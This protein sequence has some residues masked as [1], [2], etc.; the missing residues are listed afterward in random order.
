MHKDWSHAHMNGANA[1]AAADAEWAKPQ[2]QAIV[3]EEGTRRTDRQKRSQSRLLLDIITMTGVDLYHT[4][5]GTP[6]ADLHVGGRR[7]T[8]PV[9][10][11]KFRGWLLRE[12]YIR[13]RM[14]ASNNAMSEALAVIEA[15]AL[16]DGPE[17]P[18]YLRVAGDDGRIY[19]DLVDRDWR[20]VE[21]GPDGWRIVSQPP[22]RFRRT[23]GMMP[24]PTPERG[25]SIDELRPHLNV[26]EDGFVLVVSWLLAG[27]RPCGPYPILALTGE[28]GTGKSM[29]AE[30]VRSL[31]DPNTAPLRP[32]PRDTRDLY[33][34][35]INGHV[36]VFDNLSSMTNEISDCLC[37]LSTG[38]GFATRALFTDSSEVLF[39]GQRPIALTSIT[40]V[41]TRSDL[42]DRVIICPLLVIP[43]TER[44]TEA[45]LRATFEKAKP[46]IL[47]A[48]FDVIAHGLMQLPH[49]QLDRAPRMADYAVWIRACETAIWAA[50]MHMAA[51]EAN[52]KDAVEVVLDCDPVATA[53]LQHMQGR[54]EITTTATE[55]LATL[56][57]VVSDHVRRGA[58]WPVTARTLSGQLKRLAPALRRVGI[59]VRHDRQS[60][61]RL[62]QIRNVNAS[63]PTSSSFASSASDGPGPY[64]GGLS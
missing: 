55:L 52:R 28:Q 32:L 23:A 37:R 33:I 41:A 3:Q 12:Y 13:E 22:V 59:E 11:P 25:G 2:A 54:S 64:A 30:K 42:A 56:S 16:F 5:D 15:R 46:R 49:T 45:A 10:S 47:G 39:N 58:A 36:L 43:E 57:L 4:P 19:V 20:A 1:R 44:R 21:I 63:T 6:Y 48:L 31:I 27:L 60:A 7:E 24:L 40:D 14:A 53:L 29:T 9:K 38:G 18:V 34:A 61:R 26:D 35:A 8:W 50:G 17:R 51:Y 62:I